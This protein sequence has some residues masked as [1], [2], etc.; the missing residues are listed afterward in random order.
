MRVVIDTNVIIDVFAS[1]EPWNVAAEKILMLASKEKLEAVICAS[2]VTDI[3]YVCNK[4][5]HDEAKARE[6]IKTLF[7]IFTVADVRKKDLQDALNLKV[8]DFEDALVGTCAK[9]TESQF[10]I[11]RNVKDFEN[12]PVP[13]I[14]PQ[15]FIVKFFK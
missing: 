11:T 5:F 12:S 15:D 13:A 3:Y 14:T 7:A 10:I 4:T 8:D 6:V 9:R 1:R 2:A